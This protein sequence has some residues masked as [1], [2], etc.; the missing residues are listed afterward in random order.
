MVANGDPL[1]PDATVILYVKKTS[2]LPK[3]G[4]PCTGMDLDAFR[5]DPDG[6]S[7]TWVEHFQT[8]EGDPLHAAAHALK[9]TLNFRKSGVIARARVG[10]IIEVMKKATREVGVR[11]DIVPGND[12]HCLIEGISPDELGMLS[13]LPDAFPSEA[14]K[15]C[16]EIPGLV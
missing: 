3:D 16:D 10:D 2:Q 7:V 15:R 4:G 12:G 9:G 5:C 13:I 8:A 14:F 1:P 11:R 6:I